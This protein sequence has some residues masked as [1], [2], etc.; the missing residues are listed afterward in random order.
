MTDESRQAA[1]RYLYDVR[2]DWLRPLGRRRLLVALAASVIAAHSVVL[3]F[4][5]PRLLALILLGLG[6]LS[7]GLLRLAV[8]GMADLPEAV[9]DERMAAVRDRQYRFAYVALSSGT[10]VLLFAI[11]MGAD[12]SRVAWRPGAHHLEALLWTFVLPAACLPSMLV[13][14]TEPE[15]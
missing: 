10:A 8:R 9:I 13:A 6:W 14:W 4:Q 7:Y 2:F 15:V 3:W 11:W 1:E 5:G 12:A